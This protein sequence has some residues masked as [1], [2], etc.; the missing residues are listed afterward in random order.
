MAL[1]EKWLYAANM[2][3]TKINRWFNK[4]TVD[5]CT[6][7]ESILVVKMDEIG[8]MATSVH[9]F[10]FLK[11]QYP[12]AKITL[13]CRPFVKSLI[14]HDPNIDIVLTDTAELKGRF[15]VWVELR[16]NWSTFFKSLLNC[17]KYRVDRGSIRFAQRGNQQHEI[18]TNYNVIDDLLFEGQKCAGLHEILEHTN[19][20]PTLYPSKEEKELANQRIAE[21][22]LTKFAVI[23]PSA[24]RILRQWPAERFAEIAKILI[25]EYQITPLLI[26]T[27]DE[28]DC[29]NKIKSICN[30]CE[31]W[32]SND[33]LLTLF[34]VLQQSSIFIGNESGPLQLADLSNIPCVGLFGPGVKD[35]F[36]PQNKQAAVIHHV[37][38]CNPCNQ[39]DCISPNNPCI[40]LIEVESV[41]IE[42]KKLLSAN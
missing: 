32:V 29:L 6:H 36:Y 39:I 19:C 3:A 24:R 13:L 21:F 17:K 28:A 11:K 33:S 16:G 14:Q 38:A 25:S 23:H 9:V 2:V 20:R 15:D 37:L 8:D 5:E 18:L 10:S 27:V 12:N 35:V 42:L 34:A 31:V 7:I 22:G 4:P 40:N 41:K 1:S 26:G 30:E